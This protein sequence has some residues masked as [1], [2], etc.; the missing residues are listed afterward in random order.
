MIRRHPHVFGSDAERA[1]GAAP[2][3]WERIKAAERRRRA[4]RVS[5]HA[6]RACPASSKA[7]EGRGEG[8][9]HIASAELAAASHPNP[10]PASG[11]RDPLD[12]VPDGLPALTRALK[13]QNKAA[14]VGFDWPSLG[15]VFDKLR[16]E[17]ENWRKCLWAANRLDRTK[18]EEEFG[19]LLFVVANVARHLKLDPE[20]ALRADNQKFT[21]RFHAIERKLAEDG[22]TPAQS[23]LAEMDLLWDQAKAGERGR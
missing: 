21:R 2:G 4:A 17:L 11:E 7:Q 23:T 1:A 8:Q 13:L 15:L 9:R 10:P 19:D 16:E 5:L 14:R 18:I 6:L 3:F 12:G 22:R 20:A